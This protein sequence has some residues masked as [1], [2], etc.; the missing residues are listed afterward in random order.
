MF[1]SF[2]SFLMA[3]V[4]FGLLILVHELG[5]FLAAKWV[6][7]RVEVFSIG[8]WKSIFSFRRGDTEYRISIIPLGGYVKLAGESPEEATG[9]PDEFWSKTPGQR[10]LVFVAG[11]GMNMILALVGFIAAF[12]VGV[13]FTV[14]QVGSLQPAMPAWTAGM[15][16]GDVI[17]RVNGVKDPDFQDVQ[18]HV[19]LKGLKT[20]P[21]TVRRD[22]REIEMKITPEYDERLGMRRIGFSPPIEPVVTGLAKIDGEEGRSPAKDAGIRI[23]DRVVSIDGHEVNSARDIAE[24]LW[25]KADQTVEVTVRRGRE[26]QTFTLRPASPPNPKLGISCVSTEIEALQGNGPAEQAG[27]DVGDSITAVNAK[28]VGSIVAIDRTIRD[29]YGEVQLTVEGPEGQESAVTVNLPDR[30]AL[31]EFLFSFECTTSNQLTWLRE[32]GP[33][34][35]AGMRPGDRIVEVGGES[36][37]TWE[38]ILTAHAEHGHQPRTVT[39]VREGTEHSAEV[40][41]EESPLGRLAHL[42]V[43]FTR[44][45]RRTRSYGVLGAVRVGVYKT[46]ASMVDILLTIRGFASQEVSTRNVGGVVLIAYSSYRAAQQGLGKLLYLMAI[47]SGALAFLNILPIPVLDGGHLLFVAIE[48]LRGKP[49]SDRVRGISQA[50]GLLLLLSLVAYAIRNDIVRLFDFM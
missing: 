37:A 26:R 25:G 6:G 14:A 27:L 20:V 22:G 8:F 39:W 35:E 3:I 21:F 7:V 17:T 32:G 9:D 12:T 40:T 23:G 24:D 47:I 50:V 42:G 31:E 15:R 5:H 43:V 33:A 49:V 16:R 18:R 4:A 29:A 13:P 11:V 28:P 41:P 45:R 19:A 1:G 30:E 36:V 38:E 2:L 48:K 44:P 10:A 46:Y 34:W